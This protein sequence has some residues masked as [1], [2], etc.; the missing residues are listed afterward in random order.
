[1][2]V[3]ATRTE[4]RN[5]PPAA[6]VEHALAA[7]EARLADNGALVAT[8]GQHT[9]RS[10]KDKFI[11]RTA[12]SSPL[13]DWSAN[14][15]LDEAKFDTLTEAFEAHA[16]AR[17]ADGKATYT[18]DGF[19]GSDTNHRLRVRVITELAWHSL[20]CRTL[21][22][23][24][25]P[26][27]LTHFH[28]DLVIVDFPSLLADPELH[29]T[30]T[31]TAIALHFER[32][33]VL[34]AGTEYAGE[35]KKAAFTAM[36]YLMPAEGV[37]PMH[38][39]ANV[40]AGSDVALF[41]G[42]S[43]TGKTTLSADPDRRLIGD[44]EHG[45]S[46]TGVFNFEGGCYA[47]CIGLTRE[48]E[49]EIYDAIRFGSVLENVVLQPGRRPD[50]ADKSL[51]ENTRVAYPVSYIPGAVIPG[52]AG[53]PHNVIF[54]TAD[55]TGVLPPVARLTRDQALYHFLSGYTSKLA[56][57]ERGVT[58]PQ[59]VFS[60]CFGQPFL[61]LRPSAYANML[62]E[63]IDKH[64]ATCW[65]VNTGWTGGAYGQGGT[66][67]SLGHTRAMI[68]GILDHS[69]EHADFVTDPVFGLAVPTSVPNVPAGV[70]DPRASWADPDAYDTAAKGLA[71]RF[72]ENFDRFA[73]AP[74]AVRAAGPR[75]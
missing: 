55:A 37:L 15:P 12:V 57:T 40:G 20:F 11:V 58:E 19:V 2:T 68:H 23:R 27:D 65:L 31:S 6:L 72:R 4:R 52:I 36:N 66:R 47:K 21:F 22:V 46:D 16:A 53:H 45:W 63:K 70:L 30:R 17:T 35:M 28:P 74:E 38:C 33:L 43:G 71:A 67:M 48:R 75:G 25:S 51:T 59:A 56:G 54:L 39:S 14:A 18:F 49:P 7:G 8:T 61:P 62:G 64:Q 3:L 60:T 42:L 9:G 1:M 50:Y 10:P 34:V 24:P 26:K 13:V 5:L 73:D 44:D 41:F 29:G 69:L 32:R